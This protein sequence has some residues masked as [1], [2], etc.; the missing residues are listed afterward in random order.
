MA[1]EINSAGITFPN[2]T[3]AETLQQY[4]EIWVYSGS[5]WSVT[6]GGRC[7]YWTIPTGITSVK[8][9]ILSG[10]GPGGRALNPMPFER[11][12]RARD[13]HCETAPY[14]RRCRI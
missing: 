13:W 8:F 9:E 2:G 3:T 14:R 12:S 4:N 1:T 11:R 10:G 5:K 7:C 6:N